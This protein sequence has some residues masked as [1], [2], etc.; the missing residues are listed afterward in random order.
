MTFNPTWMEVFKQLNPDPRDMNAKKERLACDA[1][2]D[3][4][5]LSFRTS[6]KARKY[7]E[8]RK[9][10]WHEYR[11]EIKKKDNRKQLE[12]ERAKKFAE[13][14]LATKIERRK[15]DNARRA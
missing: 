3:D 15:R 5:E 2:I 1:M 4:K 11:S 10:E 14:F 13:K 7:E 8:D 6:P 9:K 12:I